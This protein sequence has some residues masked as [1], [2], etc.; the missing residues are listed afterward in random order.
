VYTYDMYKKLSS[1]SLI[2]ARAQQNNQA[3]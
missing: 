1:F 2:A 3:L